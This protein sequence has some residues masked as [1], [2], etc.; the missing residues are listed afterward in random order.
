MRT[1]KLTG[2]FLQHVF[3]ILLHVDDGAWHVHTLQFFPVVH[4]TLC[5]WK[6]GGGETSCFFPC[7]LIRYCSFFVH[8]S[9]IAL[10][11]AGLN[12]YFREFVEHNLRFDHVAHVTLAPHA[13]FIGKECSCDKWVLTM[14][15]HIRFM[16]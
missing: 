16:L 7:A 9:R 11:R 8:N 14:V 4:S 15:I 10:F 13:L 2:Y 12:R 1:V 5:N 6:H 3:V